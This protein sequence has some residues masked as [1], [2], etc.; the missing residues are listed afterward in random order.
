[1]GREINKTTR[2][3]LSF[4]SINE[5]MK[6]SFTPKERGSKQ[7]P[8]A[9]TLVTEITEP[10]SRES[11]EP[12]PYPFLTESTETRNAILFL[13]SLRIEPELFFQSGYPPRNKY[14]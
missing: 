9:L 1:M 4:V 2:T 13:I 7:N 14:L 5:L 6:Y 11:T 8:R 10:F 3:W 12:E